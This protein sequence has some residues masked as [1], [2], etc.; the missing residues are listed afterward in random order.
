MSFFY[1]GPMRFT[2]LGPKWV[3]AFMGPSK[4]PFFFWSQVSYS[5]GFKLVTF[6]L[7]LNE[8]PLFWSDESSLQWSQK[9]Y[10]P[11]WPK[12]SYISWSQTSYLL[13]SLQ[14]GY[15]SLSSEW[16]SCILVRLGVTYLGPKWV[17]PFMVPNKL[18]FLWSRINYSSLGFKWGNHS[19]AHSELLLFRL[20]WV[21]L[22]ILTPLAP[23]RWS[24]SSALK[25]PIKLKWPHFL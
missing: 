3:T 5:F 19:L 12:M 15:S 13:Y 18:P 8:L 1:F 23:S 9:S 11:V 6:L 2:Y 4:I 17:T 10:S 24:I 20:K 14:V 7:V 25:K 22:R 21:T 16:V